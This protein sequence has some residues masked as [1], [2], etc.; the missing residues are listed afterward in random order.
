MPSIT[1]NKSAPLLSGEE[2]SLQSHSPMSH[3][4]SQSLLGYALAVIAAIGW[5]TGGLLSKWLMTAQGPETTAW[6]F[7]PAGIEIAP[8]LLSGARAFCATIV[9][10]ML[11]LF[12]R[13]RAFKLENL[14]SSL[15]FLIP[16]G[17]IALAGM[18]FS[19]FMAIK[20][21]DVPTAILLEY[22]A[23]ILTLAYGVFILKRKVSW[24]A[25][26]AVVLALLGCAV[27]IG[28]FDAGGLRVTPSGLFWGIMAAITFA[29]YSQMGSSGAGRFS[30]STLLFY[31][32][33][34]AAIMW[35]VVL[36]PAS[37]AEVFK[38]PTSGLAVLGMS[39][40]S[41]ILPFGCYLAAM[42]YISPTQAGITAML[43]PVLVALGS[44][45]IYGTSLSWSFIVG[46]L[47][48]IGAIILIQVSEESGAEKPA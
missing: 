47:T 21:S 18:H 40:F 8:T 17:M 44:W 12:F 38:N 33:F 37:I 20:E 39:V 27:V 28:A 36:G 43:E 10:G 32:L 2:Q 6:I 9:L 22:M 45:L 24:L 4:P 46:G 41:T 14:K 30:S 16:F 35:T 19:Y 25:P 23:P 26:L 3:T 48:I 42:K 1:A 31:G 13:R 29:L 34:F 15:L 5:A 11:L 7:Q